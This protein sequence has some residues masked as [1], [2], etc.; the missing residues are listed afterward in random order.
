MSESSNPVHSVA[1]PESEPKSGETSIRVHPI[2]LEHLNGELVTRLSPDAGTLYE[3]LRETSQRVP[4][5]AFLGHRPIVDGKAGPY[6]WQSYEET[7]S[8]VDALA[9]GLAGTGILQPGDN[10]GIYSI[11]RPEWVLAEHACFSRSLCTVPLYDTLGKEAIE[12][13]CQQ[14]EMKV[15]FASADRAANILKFKPASLRLIVV[16]DPIS[17]ALKE[18]AS[19]IQLINLD[20]LESSGRQNQVPNLPP[21]PTDLFTICYTSGT[22]GLPKGVMLPH[23]AMVANIAAV[24][25]IGP[26]RPETHPFEHR[27]YFIELDGDTEIHLSYLPLAHVFE[28]LVFNVLMIVGGSVG[29]YQGDPLR[30]LDDVEALNPTF[31]VTVP[32][33]SNRIY[34]KVHAKIAAKGG[35]VNWLFQ[36]A[37]KVKLENLRRH[38]TYTHWLWDRLIFASIKAKLGRNIRTIL[39]GSAP[40]APHVLEFMRVA[41]SCEVYEG[42]GQTETCGGSVC[43]AFGDW[44]TVGHVGIALPCVEV[45]LIDVPEMGLLALEQNRGEILVRGPAC[46]IGYYKDEEKTKET[47]VDGWV[48]TGDIGE[49]D[50]QGRLRIV[51]RKKN[52]FKLAQGEYIAPERVENVLQ[53]SPL[54]SQAFVYGDSLENCTVAILIPDMEQLKEWAHKHDITADNDEALLS[55]PAVQQKFAAEVESFGKSGSKQLSGIEMPRAVLLESTPFS[56][57]NGFL[58]TTFKVKRMD[59]TKAYRPQFTSLYSLARGQQSQTV[60]VLLSPNTSNQ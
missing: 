54:I 57:E 12:Y 7:V 30:L 4:K 39:S 59:V 6:V 5:K 42:Y 1:R 9:S 35:V 11:N 8:R 13:I 26:Y 18:S 56:L 51:D 27:R 33:V 40:L 14:T 29:F 47:L 44:S 15:L 48:H 52:I 55:L 20:D 19:D 2:V 60:V 21:K 45:K 53:R 43:A 50:E 58:T 49:W 23:S 32:R 25:L 41:F 3:V 24:I 16:F 28:R 37:L 17:E 31:F 34:E 36:H 38:G 46:F 22:T 10:V